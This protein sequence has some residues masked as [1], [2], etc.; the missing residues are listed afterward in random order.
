MHL[1]LHQIDYRGSNHHDIYEFEMVPMHSDCGGN[2][3]VQWVKLNE[4]LVIL[5]ILCSALPCLIHSILDS[6]GQYQIWPSKITKP[7]K[8]ASVSLIS[9][10]MASGYN[11]PN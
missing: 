2:Y 4:M 8:R 11:G 7:S 1:I 6:V 10:V 9:T 5:S 3:R